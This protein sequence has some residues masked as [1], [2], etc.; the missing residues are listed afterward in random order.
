[1]AGSGVGYHWSR[2]IASVWQMPEGTMRTV[3]SSARGSSRVSSRRS[4]SVCGAVATAAL[5]FIISSSESKQ[6]TIGRNRQFTDL[7]TG[8]KNNQPLVN[9]GQSVRIQS[10]QRMLI[11]DPSSGALGAQLAM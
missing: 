7:F 5:T 3:T 9:L 2:T 11:S 8:E 4:K 10:Y 1:T 6:R